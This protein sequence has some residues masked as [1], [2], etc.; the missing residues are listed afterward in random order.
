MTT[1][2]RW[3]EDLARAR[4]SA[5]LSARQAFLPAGAPAASALL[6]LLHELQQCFGYVHDDAVPMLAQALNL[7]KAEVRGV[8]SFYSD[9][10]TT[11]PPAQALKLCRAEACQAVGSE[12]I[13]AH[14]QA[15]HPQVCV[16]EVFCLGNCALGPAALVG[17]E[18]I[19][20]VDERR[21]DALV[22]RLGPAS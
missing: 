21:A 13:A 9:F 4:I 11:P 10:R 17:D 15:K 3:S 20:R 22:K 5:E 18:L 6:P 16:E 2:V 8:I 7:S 14:L 19:G 1:P 12:R